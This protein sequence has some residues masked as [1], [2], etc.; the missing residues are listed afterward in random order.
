MLE[1][2]DLLLTFAEIMTGYG[3]NS[4]KCVIEFHRLLRY[5]K[6]CKRL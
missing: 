2:V 5:V 3:I 1:S 4:Y 6:G